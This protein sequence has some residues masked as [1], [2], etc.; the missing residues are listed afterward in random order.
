ML[1][2]LIYGAFLLVQAGGRGNDGHALER[3]VMRIGQLDPGQY[4]SIQEYH[5]WGVL[6]LL[7]GCHD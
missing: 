4:A 1:L 7:G 5:T 6:H 3:R 2:M